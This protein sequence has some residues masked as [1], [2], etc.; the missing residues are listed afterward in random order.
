MLELGMVVIVIAVIAVILGVIMSMIK[1]RDVSLAESIYFSIIDNR[2]FEIP[3]EEIK[4]KLMNRYGLT[5]HEAN[6]ALSLAN[7]NDN[8][9]LCCGYLET[10]IK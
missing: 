3:D 7:G 9:E 8:G 5:E 10:L 2:D 4:L 6:T 1:Q